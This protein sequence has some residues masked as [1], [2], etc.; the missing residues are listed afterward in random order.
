MPTSTPVKPY[1][2]L[3]VEVPEG[4]ADL[5]ENVV[6]RN[7]IEIKD[8]PITLKVVA[9]PANFIVV[10]MNGRNLEFGEDYTLDANG[11]YELAFMALQANTGIGPTVTMHLDD[12]ELTYEIS[13]VAFDMDYPLEGVRVQWERNILAASYK[14]YRSTNNLPFEQIANI[15][16][17]GLHGNDEMQWWID[18]DGE[19]GFIY[20]VSAVDA[21]GNEGEPSYPRKVLGGPGKRCL[22]QGIIRDLIAGAFNRNR[23][24]DKRRRSPP[25]KPWPSLPSL[26]S[27]PAGKRRTVS[28]KKN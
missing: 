27:R 1:E 25:D 13:P 19:P 10:N 17:D 11:M 23:A 26:V 8:S 16:D 20:K 7:V 14:I 9:Y 28:D 24:S 5:V 3:T 4:Q 2:L 6:Y 15:P 18:R 21:D 12:D 22:V